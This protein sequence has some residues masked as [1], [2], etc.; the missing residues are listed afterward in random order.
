MI[1]AA[2][3]AFP[4]VPKARHEQPPHLGGGPADQGFRG[5]L[6]GLD[7]VVLEVLLEHRHPGVYGVDHPHD[8][9]VAAGSRPT[10]PHG[11][12]CPGERG[13]VVGAD[14]QHAGVAA[15]GT[16]HRAVLAVERRPQGDPLA[17]PQRTERG[18]GRFGAISVEQDR[19]GRHP[20]A[21]AG[22]S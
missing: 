14:V 12:Q 5:A 6:D 8:E 1:A 11:V 17:G 3:G 4:T 16:V 13:R 2:V 15:G 20:Q 18:G 21:G 22:A 10:R 19:T 7:E 9:Q